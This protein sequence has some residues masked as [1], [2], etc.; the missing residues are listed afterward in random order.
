MGQ[1]A[2]WDHIAHLGLGERSVV[3]GGHRVRGAPESRGSIRA[4]WGGQR[5]G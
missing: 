3:T 1:H 4:S 5:G 2:E